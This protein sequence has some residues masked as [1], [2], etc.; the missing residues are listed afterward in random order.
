MSKHTPGPWTATKDKTTR[1]NPSWRIDSPSISLLASLEFAFWE[2]R[3]GFGAANAHLIAAAP[4]L[5]EA[6]LTLIEAYI[7]GEENAGEMDWEDVDSAH[8][9]ALEAV[10][11]VGIEIRKPVPL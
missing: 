10:R 4:D 7:R 2:D 11:K 6:C 1:G 8:E 9:L 5:L 3:D